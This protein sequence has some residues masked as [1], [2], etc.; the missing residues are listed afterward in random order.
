MIVL[1]ISDLPFYR[2]GHMVSVMNKSKP[3]L[4]AVIGLFLVTACRNGNGGKS[5]AYSSASR[6]PKFARA[7]IRK[8]EERRHYDM[9]GPAATF[10]GATPSSAPF[11]AITEPQ[12]Y[13]T[14][15]DNRMRGGNTFYAHPLSH[16]YIT[17]PDYT[18]E[19]SSVVPFRSLRSTKVIVGDKGLITLS[20]SLMDVVIGRSQGESGG[21]CVHSVHCKFPKM[22]VSDEELRN[23]FRRLEKMGWGD[24]KFPPEHAELDDRYRKKLL[25]YVATRHVKPS[26]RDIYESEETS[27]TG[28][29]MGLLFEFIERGIEPTFDA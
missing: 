26:Q 23:D 12:G 19:L 16:V 28:Y 1:G 11:V 17:T 20:L 29:L 22:E 2:L 27:D 8:V 25:S 24:K 15:Y 7:C 14:V 9:S 18:V 5:D 21:W 6:Y 10:V 13:L 4:L 3:M